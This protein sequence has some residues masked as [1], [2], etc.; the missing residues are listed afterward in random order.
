VIFSLTTFLSPSS[1]LILLLVTKGQLCVTLVFEEDWRHHCWGEFF[2]LCGNMNVFL[3]GCRVWW[4]VVCYNV[5]R[6]KELVEGKELVVYQGAWCLWGR[7]LEDMRWKV[8]LKVHTKRHEQWHGQSRLSWVKL[9]LP[10]ASIIFFYEGNCKNQGMQ[11][12]PPT[13]QWSL[14]PFVRK[15][16]PLFFC[17]QKYLIYLVSM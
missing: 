16:F 1:L 13:M 7:C 9:A 5:C 3:Q 11:Q 17:G 14:T 12:V 15:E 10:W 4:L 2:T 6:A 8:G